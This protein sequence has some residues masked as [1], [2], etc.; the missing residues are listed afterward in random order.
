MSEHPLPPRPS[1]RLACIRPRSAAA[2]LPVDDEPS[3][4][5][6]FDQLRGLARRVLPL[7]D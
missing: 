6:V 7:P 4:A 2:L 1:L 5:Q 3:A